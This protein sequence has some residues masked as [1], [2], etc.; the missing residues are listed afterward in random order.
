MI[1]PG[2]DWTSTE[3]LRKKTVPLHTYLLANDGYQMN[4]H[5]AVLHT[6]QLDWSS[7]QLRCLVGPVSTEHLLMDV[8]FDEVRHVKIDA[9]LPWGPSKWINQMDVRSSPEGNIY[10]MEIQSGDV[11][12][13]HAGDMVISP[14]LG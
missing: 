13:I 8:V 5:D 3:I 7:R 14:H 10:L 1:Q 9:L 6:L 2:R 4:F 12:E 11:I